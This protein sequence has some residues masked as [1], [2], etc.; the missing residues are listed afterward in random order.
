MTTREPTP[1]ELPWNIDAPAIIERY[2]VSNCEL[3]Y[4]VDGEGTSQD[5]FRCPDETFVHK[6]YNKNGLYIENKISI[7]AIP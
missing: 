4:H 7:H 2:D 5:T 6:L 3:A 1:E